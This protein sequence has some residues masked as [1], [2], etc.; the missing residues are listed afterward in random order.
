MKT[1]LVTITAVALALGC[2]ACAGTP[3]SGSSTEAE[4]RHTVA[5]KKTIRAFGSDQEFA[6]D[7]RELAK[8]QERYL[9]RAAQLESPPAAPAEAKDGESLS[10][11]YADSV[12]NVQHAGVDEGGIVKVHGD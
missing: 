5:P 1:L 11:S 6:G 3:K 10:S 4:T 2:L 9:R 8:K 7:L 12:T